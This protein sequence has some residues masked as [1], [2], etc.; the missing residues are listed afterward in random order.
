M[1]FPSL[2][3]DRK[4][5]PS[6]TRFTVI[7]LLVLFV[8]SFW[9]LAE[10]VTI[11]SFPYYSFKDRARMYTI[12]TFFYALYFIVS[13]PMYFRMEEQGAKWTWKQAL[14]DGLAAAMIVFILCDFWRL[15]IGNI[16]TDVSVDTL[17]FL[18]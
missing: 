8:S 14:L 6:W 2:N 10:T 5:N 1:S 16:L 17:P 13:F 7:C 9:S 4:M 15:I 18:V 12:G 3:K 11:A